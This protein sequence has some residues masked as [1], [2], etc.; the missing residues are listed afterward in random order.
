MLPSVGDVFLCPV[1][2]QKAGV[3]S[4]VV[5]GALCAPLSLFGTKGKLVTGSSEVTL[6]FIMTRTIYAALESQGHQPYWC[7]KL[8]WETTLN[9]PFGISDYG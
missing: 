4:P 1:E 5:S 2:R 7:L 8:Q 3:K 6:K 9:S